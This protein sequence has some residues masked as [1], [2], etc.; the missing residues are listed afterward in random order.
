MNPV[1]HQVSYEIVGQV[2]QLIRVQV[3]ENVIDQVEE[4]AYDKISRKVSEQIVLEQ[5]VVGIMSNYGYPEQI[6]VRIMSGYG[7]PEQPWIPR[8]NP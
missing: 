4:I 1:K 6:A 3:L 5:I 8:A 2:E 7:Y